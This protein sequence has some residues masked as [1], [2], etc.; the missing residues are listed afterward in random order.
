MLT[1]SHCTVQIPIH[2]LQCGKL[3]DTHRIRLMRDTLNISTVKSYITQRH[4]KFH[5][6]MRHMSSP[7][8]HFL[9]S[10]TNNRYYKTTHR[11]TTSI[12]AP[13]FTSNAG[14]TR[15]ALK[16]FTRIWF[17][18]SCM[19]IFILLLVQSFSRNV[20]TFL[21]QNFMHVDDIYVVSF[22]LTIVL[23]KKNTIFVIW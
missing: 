17:H 10:F 7:L 11:P 23:L 18:A 4:I 20:G 22:S 16:N 13:Q 9:A 14:T 19:K 12:T 21:S 2:T 1:T 3:K 8:F 5:H 6:S 15:S